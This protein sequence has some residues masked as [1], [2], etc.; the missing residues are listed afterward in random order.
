MTN[1]YLNMLEYVGCPTEN[2]GDSDGKLNYL[3]GM[4]A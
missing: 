3:G 1:L 2:L 4:D